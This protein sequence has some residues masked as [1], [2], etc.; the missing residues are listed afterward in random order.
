VKPT[1]APVQLSYEE[2]E[3]Y[4]AEILLISQSFNALKFL[5]Q[6]T[7]PIFEKIG[8]SLMFVLA[9]NLC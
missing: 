3:V 1:F 6:K 5:Q 4:R 8:P 2:T 9:K 7:R